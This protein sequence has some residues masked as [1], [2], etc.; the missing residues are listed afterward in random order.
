MQVISHIE[1]YVEP[2]V[3]ELILKPKHK[4]IMLEDFISSFRISVER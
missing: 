2:P 1:E 4:Q 3:D